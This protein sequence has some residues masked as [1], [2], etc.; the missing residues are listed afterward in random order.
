[1]DQLR[2]DQKR[3]WENHGIRAFVDGCRLV[4]RDTSRT[5][6]PRFHPIDRKGQFLCDKVER[7]CSKVNTQ[8]SAARLWNVIDH[9][10]EPEPLWSIM[11][12]MVPW[13]FD[14]GRCSN[15]IRF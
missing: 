15:S 13:A 14:D 1:M 7:I 8:R 5:G 3:L 2:Q 9:Q 10:N 6:R 11:R 12:A 4:A